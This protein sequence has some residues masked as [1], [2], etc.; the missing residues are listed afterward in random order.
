[1]KKKASRLKITVLRRFKPEEVFD[2]PVIKGAPSLACSVLK[3]GEVF[4]VEDDGKMPEG[5]CQAAWDDIFKF[6]MTLR[7][8]GNFLTWYDEPGVT[9]ACCT[10]GLRPVI[11]KIERI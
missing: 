3:D 7:F 8:G 1:L 6:V 11:F 2:Q 10:D 5:F 9:V 4:I